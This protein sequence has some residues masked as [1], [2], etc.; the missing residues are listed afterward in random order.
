MLSTL[1]EQARADKPLWLPE[2]RDIF[3]ASPEA[4]PVTLRLTL[5]SGEQRDY[6]C[7]VPRWEG[8]EERRFAA[9]FLYGCVFNLLSVCSGRELCL[10]FDTADGEL[11]A[12]VESLDTVFQ[13][14]APVRHGYGK[15][16]SIAS[17]ILNSCGGAFRFTRRDLRDYTPLDLAP[18]APEALPLD[19]R[20]RTLRAEEE[21]FTLCGVDVGG[22][23]IK[24]ALAAGARLVCTKEYDWNPAAY[25]TAEEI[26]EPILL[27]TRLMRARLHRE[28][29]RAVSLEAEMLLEAALRKDAPLP[30][31][32]EAVE[33]AERLYGDGRALLDGVGLSY[34]DI[35]IGDRILGGETPKTD[36]M[37]R[38]TAV[39]YEEAFAR[40]SSLKAALLALCRP[41]GRVHITNDGNMAA[42]TAAMEL[43][44]SDAA[45]ELRAGVVAHSI[46]TDLGTGWLTADGEIPA[47]PLELYGLILDLGSF[48]A[49]A[50]PPE[51][52][53]STRNINSGLA[54][55][56]RYIGQAAAYRLAQA[57]EP[58]LLEGF[59]A[60]EGETLAIASRPQDMRKPCL[61]HLMQR[62]G[63]GE[64]AACA[65]FRHIGA[66]IAV[67]TQ[68]M[69][70]LL[71][72]EAD[73]RFLFGRLVKRPEVF[74]LLEQGFAAQGGRERLIPSDE[75]L[76]RTPLMRAL[77]ACPEL[78]VAQFGQAVGSIYFALT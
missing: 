12:L 34:P 41:G 16:I 59:A 31:I 65:V 36:G 37:R 67:M 35:V 6:P 13:L 38:N 15:V 3:L 58:A 28:T 1:L 48:R 19:E 62:A 78:T 10:Y 71:H 20:L 24:L 2:L 8:E 44:D 29:G 69:N 54:D 75:G 76:A 57:L 74:R 66:H 30:L 5:H 22:T 50:Y 55:A 32:R 9:E 18:A 53:R 49:R 56:R 68:E 63:A 64:P 25:A 47:I 60:R 46:G 73:T 33:T 7:A 21:G 43:A 77:A 51:D 23:D 40:L 39:D 4:R 72:P 27:L 14:D 26:L 17:R 42:F 61:E 52:L 11:R 45:G 70:Y